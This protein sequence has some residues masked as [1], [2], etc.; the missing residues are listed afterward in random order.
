MHHQVVAMTCSPQLRPRGMSAEMRLDS[1]SARA[2]ILED[3]KRATQ[4][5]ACREQTMQSQCSA[6]KEDRG[7]VFTSARLH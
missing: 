2:Y 1:A 6:N 5:D 4:A 3:Q 7:E